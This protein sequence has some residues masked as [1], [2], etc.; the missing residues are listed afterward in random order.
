MSG[1][2]KPWGG[3]YSP[4]RPSRP[5]RPESRAPTSLGDR[6]DRLPPTESLP[7]YGE[8]R[9]APKSSASPFEQPVRRSSASSE[10]PAPASAP[11]DDWRSRLT[12]SAKPY[13][14]AERLRR[15]DSARARRIP[16][17]GLPF[18][19]AAFGSLAT[20]S[21][22]QMLAFLGAWALLALGSHLI[23]EG[24][25]AQEAYDARSLAAAPS[26]P[27]KLLGSLAVGLG[28]GLAGVVAFGFFS[29]AA[30]GLVAGALSAFVFGADPMRAKGDATISDVSISDLDA[31][32][33]EARG[34][35]AA[36]EGVARNLKDRSLATPLR[37]IG[38]QTQLILKRIEEDPGDLRRS[39]KF[40]K[41]YL[42]GVL[43]AARKYER[44][45]ANVDPEMEWKF[46]KLLRDMR[47]VAAEHYDKL[48][49]DDRTDLDVEIEVLADRLKHEA[50]V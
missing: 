49:H 9:A 8:E 41:V 5:S 13:D 43:E 16:W 34:K 39:R 3:P 11:R 33:T 46:R 2:G 35:V 32:L 50:G 1:G 40:L 44:A 31:A 26:L 24:Q 30:V 19:F 29:G 42:D 37:E 38:D 23:V 20:G 27:R 25:K 48:L 7:V 15:R 47:Q 14:A 6:A 12:S 17:F 22:G 28:V 45:Q 36:L 18:L 10:R 21:P 4:K